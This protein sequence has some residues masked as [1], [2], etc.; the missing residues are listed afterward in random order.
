MVLE[1]NINML[2]S[3]K[4]EVHLTHLV[5]VEPSTSQQELK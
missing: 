3:K 1:K 2:I 4:D 5:G